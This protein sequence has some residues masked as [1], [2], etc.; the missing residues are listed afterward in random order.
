MICRIRMRRKIPPVADIARRGGMIFT[1]YK[2]RGMGVGS[3]L[4]E[5]DSLELAKKLEARVHAALSSCHAYRALPCKVLL[6][7]A[8]LLQPHGRATALPA[9][10]TGISVQSARC[11]GAAPCAAPES[12]WQR[13]SWKKRQCRKRGTLE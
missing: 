4:V 9:T 7:V 5:D 11:L 3:S 6:L 2:A 12:C 1:F 13:H 8:C 10:R